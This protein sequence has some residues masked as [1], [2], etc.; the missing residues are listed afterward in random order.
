MKR[1]LGEKFD[2]KITEHVKFKKES[3]EFFNIIDNK[4]PN[5]SINNGKNR[6]PFQRN[7]LLQDRDNRI[8]V[9]GEEISLAI[10]KTT[11]DWAAELV[12]QN[13][14]LTYPVYP[15]PVLSMQEYLK[16]LHDLVK[17]LFPMKIYPELPLA[18]RVKYFAKEWEKLTKDAGVLKLHKHQIPFVDRITL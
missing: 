5:N 1:L 14:S 13:L 16:V 8:E 10:I 17:Y 9:T 4:Q 7:P 11:T 2:E 3:K 18:G 6:Q 15:V 12:C